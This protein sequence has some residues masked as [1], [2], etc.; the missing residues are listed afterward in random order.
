MQK[1]SDSG[2]GDQGFSSSQTSTRFTSR[3]K[4]VVG[5][6]L[7]F[8]FIGTCLYALFA[9]GLDAGISCV[10]TALVSSCVP[11]LTPISTPPH[12]SPTLPLALSP[13]TTPT[14]SP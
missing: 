8:V 3:Y 14:L 1:K 4:F 2:E 9:L 7:I 11:T 10:A 13:T 6:C 12:S 5:L